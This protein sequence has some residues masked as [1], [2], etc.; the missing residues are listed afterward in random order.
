MSARKTEGTRTYRS[1]VR[2]AMARETRRRIR[3][4]GLQVFTEL[5]YASTTIDAIADRAGVSRRTVFNAFE[6]KARLVMEIFLARVRGDDEP[7]PTQLQSRINTAQEIQ[8]PRAMIAFVAEA[9]TEMATRTGE[10]WAVAQQAA[11]ADPE[12]AALLHA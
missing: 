12:V 5:G 11:L 3:T 4:A 9:A 7:E 2:D 1:E 6:S 10:V 8:D